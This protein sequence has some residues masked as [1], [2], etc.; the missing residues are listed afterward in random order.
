MPPAKKVRTEIIPHPL[1]TQIYSAE[2]VAEAL[3]LSVRYIYRA[4]QSGKLEARKTGKQFLIT[5]DA[6]RKFWESLPM[7]SRKGREP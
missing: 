5:R 4:I 1:D 3:N 2:Q 7:A 6:V